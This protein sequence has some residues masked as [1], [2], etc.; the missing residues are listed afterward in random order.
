M[1]TPKEE[2]GFSC[3]ASPGKAAWASAGA[4]GLH[5][6][7]VSAP[8]RQPPLGVARRPLGPSLG[9]LLQNMEGG[10]PLRCSCPAK[11]KPPTPVVPTPRWHFPIPHC[12]PCFGA[13]QRCLV[14]EQRGGDEEGRRLRGQV[15]RG[16]EKGQVLPWKRKGLPPLPRRRSRGAPRSA[17]SQRAVTSP[18]PRPMRCSQPTMSAFWVHCP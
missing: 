11:S 18:S 16:K 17:G 6:P 4:D 12:P 2:D 14:F 5:C 1:G 3:S 8:Q 13:P 10:M 9:C 15:T 7:W